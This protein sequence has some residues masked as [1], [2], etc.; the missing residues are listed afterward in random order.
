MAVVD[1]LE[2]VG[3]GV[4]EV[5]G[6]LGKGLAEEE[7]GYAPQIAQDKRNHAQAMEDE[8]INAKAKI[9][10]DQLAM[11][12]K[13]GT[14]DYAQREQYAKAISDLY[15][16]PRH[17]ATLMEKLRR[18][19]HP[20]G[21]IAGPVELA[22]ATP[23]GGTAAADE[24]NAEKLAIA[25]KTIQAKK[26]FDQYLDVYTREHNINPEEMTEAQLED[27]HTKYY[28]QTHQMMLDKEIVEDP[29][30]PT[31]YSVSEV[32][33][34]TGKVISSFQGVLPKVGFIPK[35]RITYSKDQYGNE[36]QSVSEITP[37]IGGKPAGTTTGSTGTTSKPSSSTPQ[38]VKPKSVGGIL[39]GVKSVVKPQTSVTPKALDE[40]GHIPSNA[41]NPQVVE[42]AN[43][44]LDDRDVDKIPAKAKA[45]AA[46]LA[47]QYGWEQGKFTPKEQLLLKESETFIQEAAKNPALSVLDNPVSRAKLSQLIG[48]AQ[49][50]GTM[51]KLLAVG[52]SSNMAPEEAEFLRMYNQLVGTISGLGQ[53]TRSGRI[54]EATINRLMQELPNPITT[55]SAGDAKARLQRLQNEL[56]VAVQKFSSVGNALKRAGSGEPKIRKYNPQTGDFE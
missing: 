55:Q 37:M 20:Q 10:E 11:G 8:Q 34:R 12:E 22:D 28:Q 6:S 9:L 1:F 18:I 3:K 14:L 24:V 16:H 48:D 15:S 50:K 2:K 4:G 7:A 49:K 56:N 33:R 26:G 52:L 36:T 40:T 29:Q 31:G 42:F 21:A 44:L 25:R 13:Y 43:Q 23:K 17:A 19:V 46:A 5:A 38:P 35:R 47:R 30:S 51:G 45:P 39:S 54:T 32:D 27:A 53:L 41:S